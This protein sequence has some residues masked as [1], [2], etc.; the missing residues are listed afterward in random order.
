MDVRID[1]KVAL[2]TGAS[3]GIGEAI[4]A[5]FLE[6]GAA[7]VTITSRRKENITAAAD[8]LDDSRVLPVAARA[9]SEADANSAVAQTVAQFGGL[10][11]LVNNAG[12]NPAAGDL[13][14]VDLGAVGKT[15]EVNQLG[16][17]LWARAAWGATMAESG[18]SIV[19]IA[20]VGGMRVGPFIGAYN[21]SKA[22][23]I[24]LTRQLANEMA[25]GVRVNAVAP[26]VVRTRLAAALWEGVEEHTARAH[27]L[28]RIG[29]PSDVAYAVT[30]LASDAASWIT[31]VVLPVD[32]GVTGAAA[33]RG[34]GG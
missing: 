16:P 10:H 15:W 9:D 1:G 29:E 28:Q 19:N 22:A 7:G 3:R 27:P 34:L 21:I 8:R 17:L 13:A 18:G 4:A 25:P 14:S 6:S 23:V 30:F 33:A 12:T 31:G 2:I 24:H 26:S 11:I 20:S 5:Q 32:G